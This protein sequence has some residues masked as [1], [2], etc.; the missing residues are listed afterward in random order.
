[1]TVLGSDDVTFTPQRSWRS[2]RTGI[3]Y[4][5]AFRLQAGAAD[6]T[7]EPLFDDQE[8]DARGSVGTVYW[9]GV[10]TVARADRRVGRGYLELTGYGAPLRL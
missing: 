7:L 5:V 4:P 6:V 1:V 8:L 10:V 3:D 9:E 2:P